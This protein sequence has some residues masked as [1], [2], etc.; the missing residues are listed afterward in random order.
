MKTELEIP[1]EEGDQ[2]VGGHFFSGRNGV[3]KVRG[4]RPQSMICTLSLSQGHLES[5]LIVGK[6]QLACDRLSSQILL[7]ILHYATQVFPLSLPTRNKWIYDVSSAEH[8]ALHVRYWQE[9]KFRSQIGKDLL[10]FRFQVFVFVLLCSVS[11]EISTPP[12]LRIPPDS[13][14]PPAILFF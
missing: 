2:G 12:R 6:L 10:R 9:R 5:L 3:Y 8:L 7:N 14:I 4:S 1:S 11:Q 13:P